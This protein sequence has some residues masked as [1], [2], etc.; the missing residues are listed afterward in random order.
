MDRHK[1][2]SQTSIDKKSTS[3]K[4]SLQSINKQN[5]L[6]SEIDNLV[7]HGILDPIYKYDRK[8]HFTCAPVVT[9]D[10]VL[11][12]TRRQTCSII[13]KSIQ[14]PTISKLVRDDRSYGFV[15]ILHTPTEWSR[16]DEDIL[17]IKIRHRRFLN[18]LA[19][20]DEFYRV[21]H[22]VL[23]R[24][25]N[26]DMNTEKKFAYD[27]KALDFTRNTIQ[28]VFMNR[29]DPDLSLVLSFVIAVEF[30]IPCTEFFPDTLTSLCHHNEFDEYFKSDPDVK[31]ARF[32]PYNTIKFAFDYSLTEAR[33]CEFILQKSSPLSSMLT[34][35]LKLRKESI[36]YVQRASK[37]ATETIRI[38]AQSEKHRQST[39]SV[40]SGRSGTSNASN[41]LSKRF[42][43]C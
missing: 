17:L 23:K 40:N 14:S 15:E 8:L 4:E 36:K 5:Y 19:L 42:S 22:I 16:Y 11:K 39:C 33:L 27:F 12:Q 13:W 32:T 43:L 25:F 35:F 30:D 24:D 7:Q 9:R 29:F 37:Y 31:R 38:Q 6:Q 28:L 34:S 20:R 26:E 10:Q 1:G 41:L 3:T 21:L 2:S 18:G